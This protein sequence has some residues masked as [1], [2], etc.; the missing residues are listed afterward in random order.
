MATMGL[1]RPAGAAVPVS[2]QVSPASLSLS[3]RQVSHS[4]VVTLDGTAQ[5]IEAATLG[6]IDV[7]DARGSGQGWNVTIQASEFR[8]WDGTG[9]VPGSRTLSSGSLSLSAVKVTALNTDSPPPVPLLDTRPIDGS[10]VNI[11]S[12][13]TGT[14]MGTYRLSSHEPLVLSVPAS[15]YAVT[16]RSEI[17]ISLAPD[18][19]PLGRD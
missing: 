10:T 8:E 15:A 12:A 3:A 1:A 6:E 14:G 18:P 19:E 16:Y 13:E 17:R 4:A 5:T 9:Y 2:I 7:S 11:A